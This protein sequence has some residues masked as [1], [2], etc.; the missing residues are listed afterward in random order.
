[1]T[2]MHPAALWAL[3]LVP[4]PWLLAR[5]QRRPRRVVSS[6]LVWRGAPPPPSSGARVRPRW[7]WTP[8]LQAATIASLVLALSGPSIAAGGRVLIIVDLSASMGALDNGRSRLALAREQARGILADEA[9]STPVTVLLAHASGTTRVDGTAAGGEVRR[10]LDELQPTDAF[11]DL[12]AAFAQASSSSFRRAVLFTDRAE[13]DGAKPDGFDWRRVGRPLANLA[14]VRATATRVDEEAVDL[15]VTVRN[16]GPVAATTTV[17][18]DGVGDKASLQVPASGETTTVLRIEPADGI[19]AI[20]LSPGDAL[21]ADDRRWVALP[22]VRRLRVGVVG[23]AG[24]ALS[25]ALAAD[26]RLDVLSLRTLDD[27]AHLDRPIDL[28]VCRACGATP[29]GVHALVFTPHT[30]AAEAVALSLRRD[31][32]H[33]IAAG[34]DLGDPLVVP[35]TVTDPASLGVVIGSAGSQPVLFALD[36]PHRTVT[37]AI[38]PERSPL[39]ATSAFPILIANVVDWL[40]PRN[41]VPSVT[42]GEPV[43]LRA[44]EGIPLDSVAVTGPDGT[45]RSL[46]RAGEKVTLTDT[47]RAGLYHITSSDRRWN[48]ALIV[49]PD[50]RAAKAVSVPVVRRRLTTDDETP[51]SSGVLV[52][53]CALLAFV[54]LVVEWRMRRRLT[55]GR[56][57]AAALIVAVAAGVAMWRRPGAMDVV[58]VVDR[59]SSMPTGAVTEAVTLD[60]LW[61]T[62]R[63]N[64]RIGV[65]A[66]ARDAV[67]QADPTG[68]RVTPA[69]VTLDASATDIASGLELASTLASAPN[70]RLLLVSDG[71]A[72]RGNEMASAMRAAGATPIDILLPEVA[73]APAPTEVTGVAVP[74][75]RREHEPFVITADLHGR[76]G[77]RA[78]VSLYRDDRPFA[79]RAVTLGTD[80]A[81]SVSFVD[82]GESTG[83]YVF[84]AAVEDGVASSGHRRVDGGV[85]VVTGQPNALLVAERPAALSA[86][87]A[88]AGFRVQT[89]PP[90]QVPARREALAQYDLVVLDDVNAESLDAT[91][92]AALSAFVER[93]GGGLL[94]SGGAETL[95]RNG[96]PMTALGPLLP[97]DLTEHAGERTPGTNLVL[98]IDKSGSM[99][100][101]S[102]GVAEIDL[103]RRAVDRVLDVVP[104]SDALGV[105]VFDAAPTA[106]VGLGEPRDAPVLT[107]KLLAISPGGPTRVTPALAGALQMLREG[108]AIDGAPTRIVLVSDGRTT[109]ED[110]AAARALAQRAGVEI[111]TVA[112]GDEADRTPLQQLAEATGGRAWFPGAPGD[113][114]QLVARAAAQ[115]T[116]GAV[117]EE[118]F[119]PRVERHPMLAGFEG[120]PWPRLQGYVVGRVK[121]GA[122]TALVS[123]LGDPLLA[124]WRVGLGR[125]GLLTIG[126]GS[127]WAGDLSRW[128]Q[129]PRFVAQTARWTS[130][131]TASTGLWLELRAQRDALLVHVESANADGAPTRLAG[132]IAVLQTPGGGT[133]RVP[134]AETAPGVYEARRPFAETG[135]YLVDVTGVDTVTGLERRAQRGTY[136]A[137]AERL[138][139]GPDLTALQRIAD[140][141]G[142]RVLHPGESPFDAPRRSVVTDV[143]RF[144]LAAAL[145]VF[146]GELIRGERQVHVTWG[147]TPALWPSRRVQEA[148]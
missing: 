35:T 68:D 147:R 62:R 20:A 54:S 59:S 85:V 103:A 83:R 94:V 41:A 98:L 44:P 17:A 114:P 138:S 65:V 129:F 22:Q 13:P 124:S 72:T 81:S 116:G 16:D 3:L 128:S 139:D 9:A 50:V 123:H 64:D 12:D 39:S 23:E 148:A 5:R 76:P 106:V 30:T 70:R 93:D 109:A 121:P 21:H 130:R 141:S 14:I 2:F 78:R 107:R 135:A 88:A 91:Q 101:Q 131:Q 95:G 60:R 89:I 36:G 118:S 102:H 113:L 77:Q 119:T 92:N 75:E 42:A 134:L 4:L 63:A 84:R 143:T 105:L 142:G 7:A 96:Y 47:N 52:R 82:G 111:S 29:R 33:P 38:G 99:A 79:E 66:F 87:L 117:V 146:I 32:D 140:A 108:H 31:I 6:L 133:E 8:F 127:S 18:V 56:L 11:A 120:A 28:L 26:H 1:M 58:A 69:E 10:A 61:Q 43:A 115:S 144:V 25:A 97:I 46:V 40:A 125:V 90:G 73:R 49:N 100:D 145:I 55:A 71:R 24:R 19:A 126:L 74:G 34:L 80:G 27:V 67:V 57:A 112:V 15:L 86:P 51:A 122:A 110:A 48:D 136:W 104:S 37:L 45:S 53:V 132:P 137:G